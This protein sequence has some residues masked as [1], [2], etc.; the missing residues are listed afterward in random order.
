LADLRV[1]Y[2]RSFFAT[3]E[4]VSSEVVASIDAAVQQ[5]AR[6]GAEVEEIALPDFDLFNACG[7]VILTAEAYAIHEKDLLSRPLDY[8]RYTYQRMVVGATLSAADLVQA[9]RLRRELSVTLNAGILN[10]FD[11]LITATALTP[12]PRL[13]EFPVD[14]PL[15][16]TT[17]TIPFNV[18]GNPALAIPTGFSK[19]GLPLGMQIVGRPFDEPTVLRIGAAYE[20]AA[21]WTVRR[22][23]LELPIAV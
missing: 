14:A 11:A 7:R 13:D 9:F 16:N 12:A 22:P 5:I 19:S 8:A 23:P 18:T 15:R 6:L 10:T 2:P 21:G 3:Q 1:A 4:G 20:A 17:L